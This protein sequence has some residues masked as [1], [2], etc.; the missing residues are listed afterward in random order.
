MAEIVFLGTASAIP[1]E[2]HE[3]AYMAVIGS[4]NLALIDCAGNPVVRLRQANIDI[5]KITDLVLTHFHPDHV[6]GVPLLLMNSWLLGRREPI[7]I[8]GLAYTLDRVEA[9]MNLYRWDTWPGFYPV[10]FHRILEEE[11][12]VVLHNQDFRIL[13]SPTSHLIPSI[14]LRIEWHDSGKTVAYSCDTEPNAAFIRLSKEVDVLIHEASGEAS[15]HSSSRQAGEVAQLAG[16]R[17]LYLIHY[18]TDADGYQT[19]IDQAKVAYLGPVELA[20][21]YLRLD[22]QT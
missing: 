20:K 16:A 18:P 5:L 1:D 6:S 13:A 15:G 21:D 22:F 14:G 2:E 10:E 11:G 4:A 19:L 8:H 7:S 12:A 17:A 3:N 9:M